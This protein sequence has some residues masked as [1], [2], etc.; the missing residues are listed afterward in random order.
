MGKEGVR[1]IIGW[2][3]G[4]LFI[5][6]QDGRQMV[7]PLLHKGR[8]APARGSSEVRCGHQFG[9]LSIGDCYFPS[10]WKVSV[11]DDGGC[12]H[13]DGRRGYMIKGKA[14]VPPV[15]EIVIRLPRR[16]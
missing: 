14:I 16:L 11:D 12:T 10:S 1:V 4:R 6:V 8:S 5:T 13:G 7:P 3:N 9:T 15:D 2:H